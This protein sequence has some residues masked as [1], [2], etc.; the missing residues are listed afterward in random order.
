MGCARRN[1][2]LRFPSMN[3]NRWSGEESQE[4]IYMNIEEVATHNEAQVT[5]HGGSPRASRGASW[6]IA[7]LFVLFAVGVGAIVYFGI[8]SRT[9]SAA[10]LVRETHE[11]SVLA[12]TV[13][14]PKAGGA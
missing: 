11:D 14:H 4:R 3:C 6:T 2:R 7:A 12:V 10:A 8:M 9:A 5:A 1:R 13:V